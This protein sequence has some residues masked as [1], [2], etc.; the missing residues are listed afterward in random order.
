MQERRSTPARRRPP[1]SAAALVDA[2]A[3]PKRGRRP[4]FDPLRATPRRLKAGPKGVPR[5]VWLWTP[6]PGKW[7][8]LE[9]VCHL[10]DMERDA[11]LARYR[12]LLAETEPVLP[13]VDGDV[14]AR[15]RDYRAQKPAHVVREWTRLRRE[16]LRL[17]AGV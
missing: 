5:A 13:D 14:Y 3:S 9:I 16:S 4:Q 2:L 6:P 15:D 1:S 10:R 7:S 11:Y 8:I 12:R 17:L